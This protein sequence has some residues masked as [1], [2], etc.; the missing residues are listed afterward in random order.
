M[1]E[2][3][4]FKIWLIDAFMKVKTYLCTTDILQIQK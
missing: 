4:D 3:T 1:N 2:S